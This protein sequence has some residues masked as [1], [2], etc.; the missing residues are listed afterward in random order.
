MGACGSF[1]LF[2]SPIT[3][4]TSL[5][6]Q[7]PCCSICNR[8][9]DLL[10]VG[11]VG[12]V[13]RSYGHGAPRSLHS[14]V[15]CHSRTDPNRIHQPIPI[16]QFSLIAAQGP[17]KVALSF[18]RPLGAGIKRSKASTRNKHQHA[19]PHP[20]YQFSQTGLNNQYSFCSV[21]TCATVQEQSTRGER[22]ET[23]KKRE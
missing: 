8:S 2:L 5:V 22:E 16:P 6:C 13:Y 23:K 21:H 18:P 11:Y 10:E 4:T 12:S 7:T 15:C 3:S 9:G 20:N 17:T 19:P 14:S 1:D